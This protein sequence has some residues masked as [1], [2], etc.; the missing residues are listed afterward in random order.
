[1]LFDILWFDWC[2]PAF[3]AMRQPFKTAWC[4]GLARRLGD[5]ALTMDA[6]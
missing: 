5:I 4:T 3:H 6:G 1:M 2:D